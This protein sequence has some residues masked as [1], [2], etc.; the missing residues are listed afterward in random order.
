[1][2]MMRFHWEKGDKE[3]SFTVSASTVEECMK[4]AGEE[5]ESIGAEMIDWYAI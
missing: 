1:M 5:I 4:I 2:E 3:G